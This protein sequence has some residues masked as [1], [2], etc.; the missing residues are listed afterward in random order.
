MRESIEIGAKYI[1]GEIG[2]LH[3]NGYDYGSLRCD[4]V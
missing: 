4:A 2:S 3:V 1:I